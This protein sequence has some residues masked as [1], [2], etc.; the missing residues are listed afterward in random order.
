M[1]LSVTSRSPSNQSAETGIH[2]PPQKRGKLSFGKNERQI[3]AIQHVDGPVI[4]CA[5]PGSGKTSVIVERIKYLVQEQQIPPQQIIALTFTR[6]AVREMKERLKKDG[7]TSLSIRTFHSLAFHILKRCGKGFEVCDEEKSKTLLKESFE[8]CFSRQKQGSFRELPKMENTPKERNRVFRQISLAKSDGGMPSGLVAKKVAEIYQDTLR[9]NNLVDQDGFIPLALQVLQETQKAL[10]KCHETW[11]HFLVD[12]FQDTNSTQMKLI[13]LLSRH[14]R[15]LF[16]VGDPQQSIYRFR[17]AQPGIFGQFK[18]EYVCHPIHLE[19]NYRCSEPILSVAQSLIE[20]MEEVNVQLCDRKGGD[21]VSVYRAAS[22][23]AEAQFV[24]EEIKNRIRSIPPK[25]IA[26]LYRNNFQSEPFTTSCHAEGIHYKLKK[27][28]DS[29]EEE[30]YQKDEIQAA[31]HLLQFAVD[32]HHSKDVLKTA[33]SFE[34]AAKSLKVLSDPR[35][36]ELLS[37]FKERQKQSIQAKAFFGSK[38]IDIVEFCK[39]LLKSKCSGFALNKNEK[40]KIDDFINCFLPVQVLPEQNA[41]EALHKVLE[42]TSYK[43]ALQKRYPEHFK[44]RI[45]NLDTLLKKVEEENVSELLY[46]DEGHIRMMTIHSA[47]GLEFQVVFLVG[48]EQ[49]VLPNRNAETEEELNEEKRIFY[50]GMTRAKDKLYLTHCRMRGD[51]ELSRGGQFD[52]LGDEWVELERE[53]QT[54]SPFLPQ[55]GPFVELL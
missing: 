45:E 18:Q 5:G 37:A 38:C 3:Q 49:G 44:E 35:L 40:E 13:Q 23:E 52:P 6:K 20:G 14:T 16:V 10:Q 53:E 21:P 34:K 27:S 41:A 24:I 2:E 47:K 42:A 43:A 8:K 51:P 25:E 7:F 9:E 39:L 48:L 29:D 50:V 12:E 36:C 28:S 4:V 33:T 54:P 32:L 31:L 11:T 46:P 30:F 1:A 26:I 17:G 15:N 19:L 22:P 55:P